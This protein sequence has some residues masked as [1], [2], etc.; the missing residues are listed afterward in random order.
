MDPAITLEVG[1]VVQLVRD[2]GSAEGPF[3]VQYVSPEMLELSDPAGRRRI[4]IDNG[5]IIAPPGIQALRVIYTPPRPGYVALIGAKEGDQVSI[6]LDNLQVVTGTVVSVENDMLE[7]KI[8]DKTIFLDFAYRGIDPSWGIRAVRVS[9]GP[10][11]VTAKPSL[12]PEAA[13]AAAPPAPAAPAP[14]AAT[15]TPTPTPTPEAAEAPED[16]GATAPLEEDLDAFERALETGTL[17]G[18]T[19]GA[20]PPRMTTVQQDIVSANKI[21]FIGALGDVSQKVAVSEEQQ[22]Y[23]L[24]HQTQDLLDSMLAEHP[25]NPDPRILRGIQRALNQFRI[26]YRDH[27]RMGGNGIALGPDPIQ[28]TPHPLAHALTDPAFSTFWLLPTTM[29]SKKFYDIEGAEEIG[30]I[31]LQSIQSI[32]AQQDAEEN[33]RRDQ[34]PYAKGR[35]AGGIMAMTPYLRPYASDPNAAGEGITVPLPRPAEDVIVDQGNNES[36][37]VADRALTLMPGQLRRAVP[38][39]EYSRQVPAPLGET[40]VESAPAGPERQMLRTGYITLGAE[41]VETAEALG[42]SVYDKASLALGGRQYGRRQKTIARQ[43]RQRTDAMVPDA[44]AVPYVPTAEAYETY[45][46][47]TTPGAGEII[48]AIYEPRPGR[49]G[50]PNLTCARERLAPYG[51]TVNALPFDANLVLRLKMQEATNEIKA[52]EARRTAA[53]QRYANIRAQA[54]RRYS[55]DQFMPQ[56]VPRLYRIPSR[57]LPLQGLARVLEIDQGAVYYYEIARTLRS[58]PMAATLGSLM[59]G[60]SGYDPRGTVGTYPQGAIVASSPGYQPGSPEFVYQPVEDFE[61]TSPDEPRFSP[62]T[63][64]PPAAAAAAPASP[65]VAQGGGAGDECRV[66]DVAKH[67]TLRAEMENDLQKALSGLLRFDP[68]MDPTRREVLE[69][70]ERPPGMEDAEYSDMLRDYLV[71]ENGLRPTEAEA[72]ADAL[73]HGGRLVRVGDYVTVGPLNTVFQLGQAEW[74]GADNTTATGDSKKICADKLDCVAGETEC[75]TNDQSVQSAL[76]TRLTQAATDLMAQS[77]TRDAYGEAAARRL[78]GLRDLL[79]TIRQRGSSDLAAVG[80]TDEEAVQ[81]PHMPLLQA[82]LGQGD[83]ATKQLDLLRFAQEFTVP[84]PTE[85][86]RV[87]KDTNVPILPTFLTELAEASQRGEYTDALEKICATRGRLSE[88]GDLWVDVHS[89]MPIKQIDDVIDPETGPGEELPAVAAASI[90]EM[91]TAEAPDVTSQEMDV[92]EQVVKAIAAA[93]GLEI[94][95]EQLEFVQGQVSEGLAK[96]LPARADYEARRQRARSKGSTKIPPSYEFVS[97]NMT[98]LLAMCALIIA[99]QTADRAPRVRRGIS[100]CPRTLM[101]YPLSPDPKEETAVRTIACV[102]N[103]IKTDNPPWGTLAKMGEPVLMKQMLRLIGTMI[104]TPS[105]AGLLDMRRAAPVPDDEPELGWV[106]AGAWPGYLPPADPPQRGAQ[107]TKP[108]KG[109][110]Y[111]DFLASQRTALLPGFTLQSEQTKVVGR[112]KPQLITVAGTP[113]T[114]NA[115]CANTDLRPKDMSHLVQVAV[116]ADR[117]GLA[118][119]RCSRPSMA[120]LTRNT[121]PMFPPIP[122]ENSEQTQEAVM[123]RYCGGDPADSAT[124]LAECPAPGDRTA[125]SVRDVLSTIFEGATVPQPAP[126]APV[127]PSP[128]GFTDRAR[129]LAD[130]CVA[131]TRRGAPEQA[132]MTA[133]VT[134]NDSTRMS[135]H[136][137]IRRARLSQAMRQEAIDQ[138]D[139]LSRVTNIDTLIDI[140]E[141]ISRLWPAMIANNVTPK[142]PRTPRHWGLSRRHEKDVEQL[143]TKQV[144]DL[145]PFYD[146]AQ[147]QPILRATSTAPSLALL[148]TRTAQLVR[149]RHG[150]NKLANDILMLLAQTGVLV[151]FE[152]T[153]FLDEGAAAPKQLGPLIAAFAKLASGQAVSTAE[154]LV[155]MRRRL[156]VAKEKEKDHITNFLKDMSD[157][158]REI[159]NLMKNNKLGNWSKGQSKELYAYTRDAYDTEMAEL[160]QR[161]MAD[162]QLQDAIGRLRVGHELNEMYDD[163]EVREALDLSGLP[164]DDDYGDGDGDEDF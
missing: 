47:R 48:E 28:P 46:R 153:R 5:E 137:Q 92:A 93:L 86:V 91:L 136:T 116:E 40:I 131:V 3:L 152:Y 27:T 140:T 126:A 50:C 31:E 61:P 147:L 155:S 41:G 104:E 45:M 52:V 144:G 56:Q 1:N 161:E 79:Q 76:T 156:L 109:R 148:I 121:R 73:I 85:W 37:A 13:A 32:D 107:K 38:T 159:E 19:R 65:D 96:R 105:V 4:P 119:R 9:T 150:D 117:H 151:A 111:V 114:N 123:R 33:A 162:V 59:T 130:L 163:P 14:P 25:S 57:T 139:R 122:K 30:G 29:V 51:A 64:S 90:A 22:R 149:L 128:E 83:F 78:A 35:V 44:G 115:C 110:T 6:E 146:S 16:E 133:G 34:P 118:W 7:V 82:I 164:E 98:V 80:R 74:I 100:G 125:V 113:Y 143:W 63:P 42:G 135:L 71:K 127:A 89:G 39:G 157:E 8:D 95:A 142:P 88:M 69:V 77:G 102:A 49:F 18:D 55:L 11:T 54:F 15:P 58:A 108:P 60:H 66:G 23:T 101:G 2:D 120:L 12:T 97:E 72:E 62:H 124:A 112:S 129:A 160:E 84:G 26:L 141:W 154:A 67:Y 43:G 158:Q 75:E 68:D 53:F 70:V 17:V 20:P 36:Y 87:C 134:L 145:T 106:S 103:R 132:T 21:R 94:S 10:S 24:T 138:I 81:S 99:V